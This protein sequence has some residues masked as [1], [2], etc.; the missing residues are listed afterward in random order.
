MGGYSTHHKEL[1][2]LS[3]VSGPLGIRDHLPYLADE[4]TRWLLM[5]A[6]VALG[7][8]AV[9]TAGLVTGLVIC[10]LA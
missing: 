2:V 9:V 7:T 6:G 5:V 1:A 4:G 8:R 10:V 3:A